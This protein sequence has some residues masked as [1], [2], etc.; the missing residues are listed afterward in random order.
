MKILKQEVYFPIII[1]IHFIFWAVDLSLYQGTFMEVSSDTL[2]FG[3]LTNESWSNMHRILGEVFSSW[4]VTVFA[5]NFLMATRARWVEK[6]FGGLDKMYLIHRRSGVIAVFL[7]LAHFIVVPRDLVEF[8]P[9]KPLGFYAFVLIIV[10][11]ILSAAPIFKRKIPYHKWINFHKLM[12]LFYVMAVLHGLMVSSLIKELPIT[13]VYVFGMSFI[14]VAAWFY[15]AFLYGLFNKKLAYSVNEVNDLGNGITEVKLKASANSLSYK[16]GQFVFVKF[17]SISKKEQ[18]PFTI[19]SHPTEGNL[20]ITVKGLG[21][22]TDNLHEKIA[23][24]EPVTIEGPFGLFTLDNVKRNDQVWIAGGIGI[25]PFLSLIKDIDDQ[26]KV[27]LFWCVNNESEAVYKYEIEAVLAN[28]PNIDFTIWAS[29][30]NGY[31]T[32]DQLGLT[33]YNDKDYLI[34]G[35]QVLKTSMMTQLKKKGVK[36]NQFHDE[37]FAFR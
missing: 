16:A 36:Q 7:L 31:L 35:P 13:R 10:G 37:E 12:G 8:N 22:Y 26:K 14:G 2:F 28:K 4:V 32:A 25:T 1:G 19:S 6:I 18:H 29:Q 30:D 34:C 5:F 21:D 11:V 27:K 24:G 3:E 9:G 15:R 17:P 20:R 23:V 33:S